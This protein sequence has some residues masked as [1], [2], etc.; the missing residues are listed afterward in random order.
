ME[1]NVDL[2]KNWVKGIYADF[3]FDIMGFATSRG[4]VIPLNLEPGTL[5]NI[6]EGVL[7]AHLKE[8][9]KGR[10]DIGVAEGG[11]RYYPDLELSG[12]FFGD[13]LIALDIKAAR[14]DPANQNR[15]KSR[16]T[17]YTFGTYLK[18]QDKKFSQ[19]IRPFQEYATH[20]DLIAFF[21]VDSQ[22]HQVLNMEFAVVEPWKIASKTKS[23]STRDYVGAIMEID[24]MKKE[25]GGDF[26]KQKEF[27]NFWASIPRR[28]G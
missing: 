8:K 12:P 28:G 2:I 5:G 3:V 4:T 7:I 18:Y 21:D 22:K 20:I 11:F 9:V 10:K 1:S 6:I 13:K 19:I 26:T 14:R 17:L 23:S 27:Y 24:K 16:I 25:S 15:T